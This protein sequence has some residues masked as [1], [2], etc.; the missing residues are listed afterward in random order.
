MSFCSLSHASQ[1][2]L[3]GLFELDADNLLLQII[4]QIH[5]LILLMNYLLLV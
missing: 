1:F 5:I 4:A 2:N 3:L